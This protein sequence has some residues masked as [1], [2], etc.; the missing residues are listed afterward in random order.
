MFIVIKYVKNKKLRLPYF[1]ILTLF[2][3]AITFSHPLTPLF[4]ML[5]LGSMVL[6]VGRMRIM[7]IPIL[8]LVILTFSIY[9][10]F[11]TTAL[12]DISRSI[13]HFFEV[14]VSVD[15]KSPTTRLHATQFAYRRINYS[16]KIGITFYSVIVGFIGL[17]FL[18]KKRQFTE[19]KFFISWSFALIPMMILLNQVILGFFEERFT[20]ISSLP[21]AFL[22]S[23]YLIRVKAKPSH[24]FII[25]ILL[26]S[27][28]FFA[29]HGNEAFQSESLEKLRVDC[30]SSTFSFNCEKKDEI[31]ISSLDNINFLGTRHNGVTREEVM[32]NSIINNWDV[33]T[34]IYQLEENAE[35]RMLDRFYS[36]NKGAVYS[37]S[38]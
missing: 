33:E 25:F 27:L 28:Y 19:A 20:L 18:I 12:R 36:T 23:Y 32:G 17:L 26:S 24:V 34:T 8:V 15:Y 10:I 3:L 31:V 1:L 6:L 29:K 16:A 30:F 21:L 11:E 37:Y 14:L 13:V 35:T 9:A 22:A 7:V 5:I 4:L 38:T 2:T